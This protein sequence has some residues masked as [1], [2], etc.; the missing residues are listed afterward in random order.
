MGGLWK[1][2]VVGCLGLADREKFHLPCWDRFLFRLGLEEGVESGHIRG[3]DN[4][5]DIDSFIKLVGSCGVNWNEGE[6]S[7]R[8]P[9]NSTLRLMH[10][11]KR[12]VDP[13]KNRDYDRVPDHS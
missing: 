4:A 12:N 8:I 10:A 2:A 11:F 3:N 6:R 5:A 7:C 9:P 13:I 1:R